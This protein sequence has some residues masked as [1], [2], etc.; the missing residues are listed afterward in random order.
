MTH[1]LAARWLVT[2]ESVAAEVHDPAALV[3]VSLQDV[4]AFARQYSGCE[5]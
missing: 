1:G 4:E 3:E 2:V 5:R